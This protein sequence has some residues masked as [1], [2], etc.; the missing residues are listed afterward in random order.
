MLTTGV[1]HRG[2]K[3]KASGKGAQSKTLFDG[4]WLEGQK[5][6][7]I[8]LNPHSKIILEEGIVSDAEFLA[9]SNI[10]DY[11]LL[12]GVDSEQKHLACGLVDTIGQH[13]ACHPCFKFSSLST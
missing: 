10:M 13:S 9:N 2:R 12:L 8:L 3:V 7:L 4:E 5:K 11:S 6:A 1:F